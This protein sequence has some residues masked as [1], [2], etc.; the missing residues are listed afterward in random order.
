MVV[1]GKLQYAVRAA[2]PQR[3]QKE[4]IF[5]LYR[6][7]SWDRCRAFALPNNDSVGA[8]RI[9]V[10]GRDHNGM[11]E[12]GREY[13][14]VC[15]DICTS[16]AELRDPISG[17][18]V[19]AFIS[20]VQRELRGPHLDQLPD[21]TVRWDTSF[22]WSSVYSPR[23]GMLALRTQDVRSGT[24]TDHG[25]MLA[26]GEGVPHGATIDGASVYDIVPTI[27]EAAG[28]RAPSGCEGRPLFPG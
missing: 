26:A 22:P 4:L 9:S 2:L 7:R 20:K 24:H 13:E 14:Q 8:I 28:L 21:I 17:K 16:L 19:A 1:P 18:P 3:L 25:F 11:V 12:P 15:E 23:F 10:R 27:M 5:R 6:N